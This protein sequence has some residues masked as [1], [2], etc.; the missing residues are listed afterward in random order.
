MTHLSP[1][2][3]LLVSCIQAGISEAAVYEIHDMLRLPLAWEEFLKSAF[4]HRVAP[5]VY[6]NLKDIPEGCLVPPDVMEQL[7]KEYFATLARNMLLYDGLKRVLESFHE[8]EIEVI[9][10]KGAALAKTVYA[11]IGMRPMGDIDI[12]VRREDLSQAE[13]RLSALGYVFC[14]GHPPEWWR[15]NHNHIGYHHPEK[16]LRVE[17]HWH[18]TNELNPLRIRD[19]DFDI[20]DSFWK[21]TALGEA[22]GG[23]GLILSPEDSLLYL[24]IHFLKHRFF[25]S[26]NGGF[27]SKGALLQLSDILYTLK[28]YGDTIDWVRFMKEGEEHGIYVLRDLVL[29]LMMEIMRKGNDISCGGSEDHTFGNANQ[30]ILELM[31]K[32]MFIREEARPY[33]SKSLIAALKGRTLRS[34]AGKLLRDIFPSPEVMSKGYAVPLKSKSLYFF[35]VKRPVDLF[36]KHRQM[37]SEI[38]RMKE[39]VILNRWIDSRANPSAPEKPK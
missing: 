18:I 17:L 24:S 28:H 32:K 33:F 14:G 11:D 27:T 8:E 37:M 35:Y 39:D 36:L 19:F 6:G 38:P 23:K 9:L 31:A 22:F 30:E 26:A 10:L 7:K 29:R 4:W 16:T 3:R 25:N 34:V 1:E 21:K 5:L 15:E 20:I 2:N 13:G 12:M